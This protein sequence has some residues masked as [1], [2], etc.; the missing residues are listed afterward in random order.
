MNSL[1]S[2]TKKQESWLNKNDRGRKRRKEKRLKN[3]TDSKMK[4]RN[5]W[6][7]KRRRKRFLKKDISR[8]TRLK[9]NKNVLL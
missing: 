6:G 3:R 7:K 1:A 2:W 9:W 5:A 4:S 8:N